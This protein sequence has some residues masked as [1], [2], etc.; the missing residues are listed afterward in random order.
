MRNFSFLLCL[1]FILSG[2]QWI[3][4]QTPVAIIIH[5]GAGNISKAGISLEKEQEYLKALKAARDN[6][7]Q[8]LEEGAKA[9]DVVEATLRYMEND[10]NFNAG[11]GAVFTNAGTN[12]LDA[13]IM[14]GNTLNAGAVAGVKTVKH[15][16]SAARKVM[17]YSSHV[18]LSG[19]GAQ[20]FAEEQGLE[21]VDPKWFYTGKRMESLKKVQEKEQ[22]LKEEQEKSPGHGI[23]DP[24]FN[25][26]KFGTVG[27][28][29]LDS[30][31]NIAAG[32][33]TGGMTNKRWGRIGDSPIIGAGTYADNRTCGI[34]CTGHGEY[35]IRYAV[36]HDISA[37]MAYKGIS[38]QK[39]AEE[40]IME[41]LVKAGGSGGIVG[42][43]AQGNI[44][45]VFNSNGMFRAGRNN[46]GKQFL[47]IY[48]KDG[49]FQGSF[50]D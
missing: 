41:E 49:D 6:G 8:Q 45:A 42:L 35:F 14:D 10:S 30:E 22:E 11:R 39:A 26:W 25:D 2:G 33:S 37:R 43:D 32:T 23:L 19:E 4:A 40:V 15:P 13:S 1:L 29:V 38:L 9:M 31:G 34:S 3:Y 12:E 20:K 24:A 18:L 36:A 5:G 21:I 7:Y 28:V 16:I 27:C 44:A 46:L 47:G 50:Q 17:E 48:Q